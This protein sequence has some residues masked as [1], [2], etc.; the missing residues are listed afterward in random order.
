[1]S[2]RRIGNQ[3]DKENPKCPI[4]NT[5]LTKITNRSYG[6]PDEIWW[7]CENCN[8]SFEYREI[9]GKK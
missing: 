2:D 6:Q 8:A 7:G 9:S 5:Y 4:C 1:M 3:I